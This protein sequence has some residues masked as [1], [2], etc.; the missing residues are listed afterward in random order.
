MEDNTEIFK[1]AIYASYNPTMKVDGSYPLPEVGSLPLPEVGS[2]LQLPASS[3]W[4]RIS[5]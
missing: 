1:Y 3:I 5:W 2:Y 4:Q